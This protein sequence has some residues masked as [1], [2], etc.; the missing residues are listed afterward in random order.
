LQPYAGQQGLSNYAQQGIQQNMFGAAIG[1]ATLG[2]IG[3][4]G[5]VG[6]PYVHTWSEVDLALLRYDARSFPIERIYKTSA[7]TEEQLLKALDWLR[8]CDGRT[9]IRIGQV[10]TRVLQPHYLLIAFEK[11]ADAAMLRLTFPIE[12]T[13]VTE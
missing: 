13:E 5:Q 6:Q 3:Q 9:A 11:Q 12:M 2:A 8:Q 10:M 4:L 1:A 7:L